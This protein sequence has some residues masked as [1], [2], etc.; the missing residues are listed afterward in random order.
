MMSFGKRISFIGALMINIFLTP[1]VGLISIL[2]T[3]NNIITHHYTMTVVCESCNKV[4]DESHKKCPKC[5]CETVIT[6][7]EKNNVNLAI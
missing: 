3:D 1:I 4:F 2:R 5:G 6:F 7:S